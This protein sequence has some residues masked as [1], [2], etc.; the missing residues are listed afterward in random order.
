MRAR[1]LRLAARRCTASS[2]HDLDCESA[3][4][5]RHH[6][7]VRPHEEVQLHHEMF[8]ALG[9]RLLVLPGKHLDSH[10]VWPL[11]VP[12]RIEREQLTPFLER[13]ESL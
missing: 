8:K 12:F 3:C 2:S 7:A 11:Y 9:H 1:S 5:T 10:P 6:G 13:L 4:C